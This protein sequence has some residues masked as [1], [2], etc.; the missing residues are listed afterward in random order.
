MFILLVYWWAHL[1]LCQPSFLHL[2]HCA[3]T[4]ASPKSL[5]WH[6]AHFF[7]CHCVLPCISI[8]D[9]DYFSIWHIWK[10]VI[11]HSEKCFVIVVVQL[12]LFPSVVSKILR[13]LCP[14]NMFI[15]LCIFPGERNLNS[16]HLRQQAYKELCHSTWKCRNMR[17]GTAVFV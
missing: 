1:S 15:V 6:Q 8:D 14:Q 5:W 13:G 3:L 11:T 16:V 10:A 4:W 17:G 12:L 2:L 9:L 7:L